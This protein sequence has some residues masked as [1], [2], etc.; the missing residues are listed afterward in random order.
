MTNYQ[1]KRQFLETYVE[2]TLI[3]KLVGQNVEAAIIN[4]LKDLNENSYDE[5]L[6]GDFKEKWKFPD[7]KSTSGEKNP[8]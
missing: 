3:L 7:L 6:D 8:R 2:M 1:K 5:G 4:M